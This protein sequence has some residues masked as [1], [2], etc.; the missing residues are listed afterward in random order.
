MTAEALATPGVSARATVLVVDDNRDLCDN[1]S[2]ILEGRGYAVRVALTVREALALAGAAPPDVALIDLNLPDGR[3]TDVLADIRRRSPETVGII[4]TGNATLDTAVEAVR[5]GAYAYLVKGG[6]I[7]EVIGTIDR[8]A[9]KVRLERDLEEQRGLSRAV[10]ANA[11]LGIAVVTRSGEIVEMNAHL[12]ELV[13]R[14]RLLL[15][16]DLVGLAADDDGRA[17]LGQALV[18]PAEPFELDVAL[19]S[20][21]R[22]WRVSTSMIRGGPR[23]NGATVAAII[24]IT[25]EKELQRRLIEGSRLAAIGEM[26][27]RVA[28]EIRNPLAGI[29]GAIRFLARGTADAEKRETF[30]R[31]VLTLLSRLNG[32]VEDLLLYARPLQ[33]S[34]TVV[35]FGDLMASVRALVADQPILHSVEIVAEDRLGRPLRADRHLLSMALQNLVQNGA[36]A[37]KGQGRLTVEAAPHE[38]GGVRIAVSDD[39]PGI[40]PDLLPRL[41]EAFATTRVEGTGLGL[42][43]V[44]R[45]IEAHGGTI[46]VADQPPVGARFVIRLPD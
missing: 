15:R 24:D 17:R 40:A 8:A 12:R 21:R 27:A 1:L 18:G 42:S 36:Q 6:R 11:S 38:G 29:G 20:G 32:F 10:L 44:K 39:G 5:H 9:E 34:K 41:F 37:M 3:G 35:A 7:E 16:D 14:P 23:V 45:V 25:D 4:L 46:S 19:P 26:A 43:T 30:A 31:E 2:E 22:T 13:G 33:V 28:H